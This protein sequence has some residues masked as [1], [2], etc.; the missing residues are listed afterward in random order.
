MSQILVGVLT[1]S[2]LHKP[3]IGFRKPRREF[4]WSLGAFLWRSVHARLPF[5]R[6]ALT[7]VNL[8]KLKFSSYMVQMG[9]TTRL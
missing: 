9:A 1:A 4:A 7:A 5:I 3:N 2:V 6:D 8:N